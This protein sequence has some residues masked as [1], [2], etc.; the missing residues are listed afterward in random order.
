MCPKYCNK[1]RFDAAV[2][3]YA[4]GVV[5][6][7]LLTGRIASDNPELAFHFQEE[8]GEDPDIP[9]PLTEAL[10][11]SWSGCPEAVC[12][13]LCDLAMRCTAPSPKKRPSMLAVLQSLVRCERDSHGEL[14][15]AEA[16]EIAEENSEL[17]AQLD[18]LKLERERRSRI[19]SCIA[20]SDDFPLAAGLLCPGL[21]PLGE[22]HFLCGP[23]GNGCADG[24]VKS[25]CGDKEEG[26]A[27]ELVH[28][29]SEGRRLGLGCSVCGGGAACGV[30]DEAVL[31]QPGALLPST[32]ET[33]RSALLEIE[34]HCASIAA[35]REAR[36]AQNRAHKEQMTRL[37]VQYEKELQAMRAAL[38]AKDEAE[39]LEAERR[40]VAAEAERKR[41][42]EE[43]RR[44][45]AASAAYLREH[46]RPCPK[47][48]QPVERM[49]GCTDMVCG[50][51]FHGNGRG[52]NGEL[53][54]CGAKFRW[55]GRGADGTI[56]PYT[57][58]Q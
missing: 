56:Q 29:T 42:E 50:R 24:H 1:P 38:Q 31:A 33:Y 12:A 5:Q 36:D 4:F 16:I 10:D 51:D 43:R 39:R 15:A 26:Y 47:C 21:G 13:E 27:P 25:R 6:L 23:T 11:E 35:A 55:T 14:A 40:M 20:C 49:E 18:S 48:R 9:W 37:T 52:V 44:N 7:E 2:E 53:L 28:L 34:W 19:Y 57:V 3:I 46:T 41:L 58:L 32:Y 30:F 22:R 17:R 45:E 54:G 8:D